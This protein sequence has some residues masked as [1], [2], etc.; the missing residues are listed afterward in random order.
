MTS[1]VKKEKIKVHTHFSIL[2]MNL[3][4]MREVSK[5]SILLVVYLFLTVL[6]RKYAWQK[7]CLR[8]P[9]DYIQ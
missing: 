5:N 8:K 9:N 2:S 7:P 1:K 6:I 3:L 4:Q